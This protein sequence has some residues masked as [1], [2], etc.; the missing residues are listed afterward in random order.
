MRTENLL[1]VQSSSK[2]GRTSGKL[3]KTGA[4]LS[5]VMEGNQGPTGE[6]AIPAP[7]VLYVWAINSSLFQ[8]H[9][10]EQGGGGGLLYISNSV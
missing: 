9:V 2:A 6:L 4:Q 1:H 10:G 5:E 3:L 7:V 8:G